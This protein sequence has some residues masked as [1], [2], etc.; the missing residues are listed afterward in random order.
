MFSSFFVLPNIN[1]TTGIKI[2]GINMYDS[3]GWVVAGGDIN[4]DRYGDVITCAPFANNGIGEC[5]VIL[6]NPQG[7]NQPIDVS[8]LISP[9]GFTIRGEIQPY[10]NIGGKFGSSVVVLDF[11]GD[12]ILDAAFGAFHANNYQGKV[13]ILYGKKQFPSFINAQDLDGTDGITVFGTEPY[14]LIGVSLE[15]AKDLN[16]D[17]NEELIIG[18]HGAQKGTG[19]SYTVYGD[20]NAPAFIN[21]DKL[22]GKNGYAIDGMNP[23][24]GLG[25]TTINAIN[26]TGDSVN[27]ILYGARGYNNH[28]GRVYALFYPK[29]ESMPARI[30]IDT[31]IEQYG[32]F[33][34]N[35]VNTGDWTGFSLTTTNI[36]GN[37]PSIVI[38]APFARPYGVN[39]AGECYIIPGRKDSFPNT[40]NLG[41]ITE[42]N[43]TTI[44]GNIEHT[45]LGFDLMN[46]KLINSTFDSIV[47]AC[48]PG[49]NNTGQYIYGIN[50]N[51]N[52][53]PSYIN[54]SSINPSTG[55]ILQGNNTNFGGHRPTLGSLGY[56]LASVDNVNGQNE[57]SLIVGAAG[58]NYDTGQTYVLYETPMNSSLP[59]A[60]NPDL[61]ESS[62]VLA[63]ALG[64]TGSAV[65][66][67]LSSYLVYNNWPII[68][69][70]LTHGYQQ[71]LGAE[72]DA[73]MV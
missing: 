68:I 3:S 58:F 72:N 29:S 25:L 42:L 33:V 63:I 12:G 44:K 39:R 53:L 46:L 61:E 52:G 2:N 4:D 56:S 14:G 60:T 37:L 51:P 19:R 5:Y 69:G 22:N 65:V 50:G 49:L 9:Y 73:D 24:D 45:L 30:S 13:Y 59:P 62:N 57:T 23:E 28:T 67:A 21:L 10:W 38:C 6:G 35:G 48:H 36:S 47:M 27:T 1:A 16:D 54:V 64:V 31:A 32:G 55:F 26:I 71:L 18:A 43:G 40:L 11:N 34:I 8:K 15:N 41:S 17:G 70:A 66:L 7:F 20:E